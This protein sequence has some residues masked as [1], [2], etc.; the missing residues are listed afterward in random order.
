MGNAGKNYICTERAHY[1]CPNMEFGILAHIRAEYSREKVLETVRVMQAAHPFLRSVIAEDPGSR[2]LYYQVQESLELSLIEKSGVDSWQ[3]DYNELTVPGW[4]VRREGMLK[5]LLYPAG[6]EFDIL[7]IAH[8]LL[9]DGRGLLQLADEFARYYC[10]GSDP[11]PVSENLIAGLG[12]LPDKSD[13]PFISRCVIDDAN[14]RWDKEH[15]RVSHEEYLDFEKTFLR[16]NP[17][18]REIITVDGAELERVHGLC[19]QRGVSVNDYLIA[20]MM[21]E[22]QT[23]KV[24]IA[25]DIRTRVSCYRQGAMGNYSTAFS[26]VIKKKENDVLA[27]A[28]RVASRVAS[29][30]KQPQ[31][32][33]LVL[34]CYLR[35]RPELIDAVAISTLGDFQSAAG[36][37]VGRNMFG[38]GSRNGRCLKNLGRVESDVISEAVFIP[39]ASPANAKTWGILTMNGRMKICS[40]MQSHA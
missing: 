1:M 36:A 24:V 18:Q 2:K 20:K 12:D 35:M 23:E 15:H 30:R 16:D 25:E 40:V 7:L 8:H 6:A 27:L 3:T 37:F 38:Y 28:E 33:M 22:E 14:R 34:A 26:V 10:H 9:C 5:A 13:L 4:D 32:E 21:Q 39:P 11:Q 29:V 19:R 31:K 17:V